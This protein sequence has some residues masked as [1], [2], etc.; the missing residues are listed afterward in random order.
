MNRKQRQRQKR[1]EQ[2]L[3]YQK[4][5]I[6]FGSFAVDDVKYKWWQSPVNRARVAAKM[7]RL[8]KAVER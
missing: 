8:R 7:R 5:Q 2:R 3:A 1:D 4:K 6:A